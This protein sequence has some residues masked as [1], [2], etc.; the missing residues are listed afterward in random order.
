[1]RNHPNPS[2]RALLC[3]G[4]IALAFL[5]LVGVATLSGARGGGPVGWLAL[6]LPGMPLLGLAA[7]GLAEVRDSG[8]EQAAR[9]A[10][11][12]GRRRARPAQARRRVRARPAPLRRRAAA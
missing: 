1:M 9:P 8:Q 12:A 7:L 6:W 2:A 4:L 5:G 10:P 11:S 3:Q